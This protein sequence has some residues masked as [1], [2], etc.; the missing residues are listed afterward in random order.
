MAVYMAA[1]RLRAASQSVELPETAFGAALI[2]DI[3]GFTP[4]TDAF[5]RSLGP[6]RG[7]EELTRQLNEVYAALVALV[8]GYGGS[9]IGFSGDAIV[10]W[11]DEEF[12]RSSAVLRAAACAWA[13][14]ARA[15]TLPEAARQLYLAIPH[16]H[17]LIAAYEGAVATRCGGR[18]STA[19][20]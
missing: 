9:V 8:H 19:T 7:A 16:H 13:L 6:H 11:F 10:C 17:A 5:A 20:G 4:L 3:S 12:E 18:Y 1:D 2:F 15:A 14:Q